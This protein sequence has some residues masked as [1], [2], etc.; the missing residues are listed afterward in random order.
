ME[1]RF[2]TIER[3]YGS[4]GTQIARELGERVHIP[5]YGEEILTEAAK[6]MNVS[7]EQMR[8]Y[9]ETA[10]GSFLYSIYMLSQSRTANSNMLSNDG[11]IFVEE[12]NVIGQFAI[13]GSSIFLGHCASEALKESEDVIKVFIHADKASKHRRILEEYGIRESQVV[14]VEKKNNKRRANYYRA[15]TGKQWDDFRDYDVV[16]DSSRL[17]IQGCVDMLAGLM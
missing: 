3:E 9:E 12:Q 6:N 11:K 14:S 17:G 13:L 16:L 15:N 4:G 5:C 8:D 2:I 10:T 1:M 7:V